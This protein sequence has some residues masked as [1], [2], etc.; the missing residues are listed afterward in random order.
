MSHSYLPA[1]T[2]LIP[3]RPRP[4]FLARPRISAQLRQIL[5]YPLTIVKADA[6]YGKTTALASFLA[7]AGG[8]HL[9]YS[10]TESDADPLVFCSSLLYAFRQIDPASGTRSLP[11]LENEAAAMRLWAPIVDALADDLVEV[12]EAETILVLDDYDLV[13]SM[14]VNG[15]TERLAEQMPPR[16][17]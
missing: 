15:I 8:P 12:L 9:W 7:E 13:D 17:H 4:Q 5:V 3:P 1:R 11:L 10:L 14:E 2:R 16:L 6:G